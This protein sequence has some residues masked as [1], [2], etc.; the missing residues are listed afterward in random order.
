M[1]VCI[2]ILFYRT[3]MNYFYNHLTQDVKSIL[4]FYQH[5]RKLNHYTLMKKQVFPTFIIFI[6]NSFSITWD[7]YRLPIEG[8]IICKRYSP[9]T[10][11]FENYRISQS[12]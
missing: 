7:S 8:S 1:C 9:A 4:K 3:L 11:S 5:K 2:G 10:R 12:N 6:M